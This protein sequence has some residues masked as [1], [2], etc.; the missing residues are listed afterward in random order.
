MENEKNIHQ[1]E[2]ISTSKPLRSLA[3]YRSKLNTSELPLPTISSTTSSLNPDSL[4]TLNIR[5]TGNTLD[6]LSTLQYETELVNSYA[7]FLDVDSDLSQVFGRVQEDASR[8]MHLH[9]DQIDLQLLDNENEEE[10]SH[11]TTAEILQLRTVI[12]QLQLENQKLIQ[13]I[14][15]L[16]SGQ[17]ENQ[18]LQNEIV[19]LQDRIESLQYDVKERDDQV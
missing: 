2:Q 16:A 11:Q 8:E 5:D 18:K 9:S 7:S 12:E 19:S 10:F 17:E 15:F 1:E 6:T 14:N 13:N 4:A 3:N